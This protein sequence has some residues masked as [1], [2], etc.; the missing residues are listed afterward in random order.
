MCI[1][2]SCR[3]AHELF[4]TATD[5]VKSSIPDDD[6]IEIKKMYSY[7]LSLIHI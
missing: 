3:K 7:Y 4:I 5:D 1:R 2:D 6:L